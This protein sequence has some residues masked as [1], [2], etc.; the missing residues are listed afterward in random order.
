MEQTAASV[1]PVA[2]NA[3]TP[4]VGTAPS[5]LEPGERY[6]YFQQ[7]HDLISAQRATR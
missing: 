1:K 6:I 5:Y 2:K 3:S 4:G 7:N